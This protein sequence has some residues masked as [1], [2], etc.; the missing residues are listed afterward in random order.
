[1]LPVHPEPAEI[2]FR[3]ER[4]RKETKISEMK[5]ENRVR[6]W[7]RCSP[8]RARRHFQAAAARGEHHFAYENLVKLTRS[9][10]RAFI[11]F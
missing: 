9:L 11:I 3:Q 1:M 6:S 2:W 8:C 7:H 4:R 5:M 10:I